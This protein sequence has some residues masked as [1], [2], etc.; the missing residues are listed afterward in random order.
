MYCKALGKP[1][2]GQTRKQKIVSR[3]NS[4]RWLTQCMFLSSVIWLL[5]WKVVCFW[6]ANLF[7]QQYRLR[8]RDRILFQWRNA[9]VYKCM[10][11]QRNSSFTKNLPIFFEYSLHLC[12]W[13]V[14][15]RLSLD[16]VYFHVNVPRATIFCWNSLSGLQMMFFV[17][18][19]QNTPCVTGTNLAWRRPENL[20]PFAIVGLG[21]S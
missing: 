8:T 7:R 1:T 5:S 11:D 19:E 2:V 16:A 18:D 14:F 12:L 17:S 9:V 3:T 15:S 10:H 20:G 6:E 13:Y 4:H 21:L